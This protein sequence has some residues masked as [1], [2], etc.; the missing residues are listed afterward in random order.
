[1]WGIYNGRQ[2][3]WDAVKARIGGG[4]KGESKAAAEVRGERMG[5]AL[6]VYST[7][8]RAAH[9]HRGDTAR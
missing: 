8:A 9:A 3:S 5:Y 6:L 7:A 2:Y 1:M 4:Q